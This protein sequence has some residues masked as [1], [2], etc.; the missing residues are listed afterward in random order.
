[1]KLNP[2]MHTNVI[3]TPIQLMT[4]THTNTYA[5]M[6]RTYQVTIADMYRKIHDFP[7]SLNQRE[8]TYSV[9]PRT[10][11][12]H[13]SKKVIISLAPCQQNMKVRCRE[14]KGFPAS[15]SSSFRSHRIAPC[16][17]I[18]PHCTHG[19]RSSPRAGGRG[20]KRPTV[21]GFALGVIWSW[22][23]K[24]TVEVNGVWKETVE[25]NGVSWFPE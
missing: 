14:G 23:W 16:I 11:T 21:V 15:S 3:N 25:V 6:C 9:K 18:P 1:M 12:W 24:E 19:W 4:H 13:P 2:C 10:D 5:C 8:R 7:S 20:E 17:Y 22:L